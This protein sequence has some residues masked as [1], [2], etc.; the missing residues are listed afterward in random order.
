MG[1]M[2]QRIVWIVAG[3]VLIVT[4]LFV[5]VMSAFFFAMFRLMDRSDAHVCGL[6]IVERSPEAVQLVGTPM[7][8]KG[9][10]GGSTSSDNGES[11]ERMTF[12]VAGPKGEAFVVAEGHR[13]PLASHLEVRIGRDREGQTIYSGPF[14]CPELHQTKP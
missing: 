4:L 2:N 6:A 9:L 12:T 5:G 7:Q 8:Q 10:T 11:N 3:V 14:D 13:S 1:G